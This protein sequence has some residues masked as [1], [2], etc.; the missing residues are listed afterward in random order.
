M[1]DADDEDPELDPEGVFAGQSKVFI[2][3]LDL[4]LSA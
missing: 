4:K 2:I 3:E 1:L